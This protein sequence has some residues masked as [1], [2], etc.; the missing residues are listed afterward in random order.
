MATSKPGIAGLTPA[1]LIKGQ[2]VALD[3]GAFFVL[4]HDYRYQRGRSPKGEDKLSSWADIEIRAADGSSER[5]ERWP[6]YAI[7]EVLGRRFSLRGHERVVQF[8]L[9]PEE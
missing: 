7:K 1:I 4:L 2:E 6:F 5:I 8:Y 3:D 9:L